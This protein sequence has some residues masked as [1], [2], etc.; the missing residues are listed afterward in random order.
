LRR[1][2]FFESVFCSFRVELIAKQWLV[3]LLSSN[4]GLIGLDCDEE[5]EAGETGSVMSLL[6][7]QEDAS[8]QVRDATPLEHMKLQR[9]TQNH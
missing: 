9:R 2:F 8:E 4:V 7:L 1:H 5:G 6:L 3:A